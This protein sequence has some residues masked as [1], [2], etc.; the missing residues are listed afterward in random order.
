M[1]HM[2]ACPS[3][4]FMAMR[5]LHLWQRLLLTVLVMLAILAMAMV[6]RGLATGDISTGKT[7]RIVSGEFRVGLAVGLLAGIVTGVMGLVMQ[8]G[9]DNAQ[10]IAIIVFSAMLVSLCVAATMGALTPL[11]LQRLNGR[12]DT[13]GIQT[14]TFCAS[15][16]SSGVVL[17]RVG[18][19]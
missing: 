5:T 1:R 14:E 19:L 8:M 6:V 7:F 18:M 16:L 13:L 12:S 2:T 17:T 9:S 4:S 15:A 10:T 3:L 11:I